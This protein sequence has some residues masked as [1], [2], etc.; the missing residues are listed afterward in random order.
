MSVVKINVLTVPAPMRETLEERFAGRAGE[1]DK[2][3]GFESFQLLRPT[4]DSDEYFVVTQWESD[5][6]FEDWMASRA[7]QQGHAKPGGAEKPGAGGE[8]TG[9]EAPSRPASSQ[10]ALRA[11][12]VVIESKAG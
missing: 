5:E 6:A 7:F 12:E 4:D 3:P 10:A 1:V 8:M 2:T 9:G 11:F